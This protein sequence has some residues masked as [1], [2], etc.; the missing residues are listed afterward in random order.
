MSNDRE[1]E[2]FSDSVDSMFRRLGLPDPQVM[3]TLTNDWDQI[4]GNP[5][6][7]RSSPL[8]IRGTTLVVEAVSASMIAFLRYDVEGLMGRLEERFGSGVVTRVEIQAP[9]RS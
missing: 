9:G 8:Y 7:T 6:N 2:H 5:W 1:L 3:A 4:A